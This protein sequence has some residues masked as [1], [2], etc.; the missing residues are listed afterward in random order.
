MQVTAIQTPLVKTG[1]DFF[2]VL[3]E[4]LIDVPEESVLVITSKIISV[5]EGRVIPKSTNTDKH[6]LAR[7]EAEYYLE[8]H[9]SRYNLMLTINN[10]QLFVNAGIDESNVENSYVLWPTNLQEWANEIWLFLREEYDRQRVGVIISDSKTSPLHWGVTGAS[11]AHAGFVALNSKIGKPDLYGQEMKMTQVN[12]AQ[13]LAV[14]GVLEMGEANEQTPLALIQNVREIVYQD[15]VPTNEEL[16]SLKIAL[17]DDLYA[18]L[19]TAVDWQ[20]GGGH[21]RS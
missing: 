9:S 18:P 15:R 17:E 4:S 7:Q 3:S 11:L 1:D 16:D 20:L 19:L 8:P 6:Q 2:E 5:C 14:A 21:K 13:A 12:V 10:N